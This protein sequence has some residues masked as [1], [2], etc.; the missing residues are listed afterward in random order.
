MCVCC[1]CMYM[2]ECMYPYTPVGAWGAQ[3]TL[4]H[5]ASL[6]SFGHGFLTESI[7]TSC[8]HITHTPHRSQ[9]LGY[10]CLHGHNGLFIC[11]LKIW[12][13]GFMSIQQALFSI[14][15]SLQCHP[16][17]IFVNLSSINVNVQYS[18]HTSEN[19]S[20]APQITFC[21]K[22]NLDFYLVLWV[23][24]N[25]SSAEIDKIFNISKVRWLQC[26]IRLLYNKT[27]ICILMYYIS[28]YQ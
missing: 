15:P 11:T 28:A 23:L 17:I 4:L 13:Q 8:Q 27:N 16:I 18:S 22:A 19:S 9:N 21:S 5:Q 6:Y 24:K 3:N 1:V 7:T 20:S 26:N 14:K 2:C 25:A 12:T 10:R